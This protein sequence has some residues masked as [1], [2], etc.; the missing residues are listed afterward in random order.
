MSTLAGMARRPRKLLPKSGI[1]HVTA[2]GVGRMQLFLDED[3][4]RDYLSLLNGVVRRWRWSMHVL[5][6]MPNHVHHVVE[7]SLDALSRGI[8]RLHGE[9]AAGFNL[10]Y[11]R[12]GHVFG[13]RFASWLPHDEEHLRATCGYVLLNPVRAGL[14]VTA[15][16]WPWSHSRYGWEI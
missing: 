9:Y 14:V 13:D 16:D 11:G 4:Y 10:K 12:W 8:H 6:L 15:Q 7:T 3:D 2:R 5:C 1:Y